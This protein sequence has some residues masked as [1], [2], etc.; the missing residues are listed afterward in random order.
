MS[1]ETSAYEES[2]KSG[3]RLLQAVCGSTVACLQAQPIQ[4][5]AA[6]RGVYRLMES[7]VQDSAKIH[8]HLSSP[9]YFARRMGWEAVQA[10]A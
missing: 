4:G 7:R 6:F 8:V 5:F 10:R 2:V 1:Q 3:R 9:L